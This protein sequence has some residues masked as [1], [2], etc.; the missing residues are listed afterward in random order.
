MSFHGGMLFLPCFTVVLNRATPPARR[1]GSPPSP[2]EDRL[3]PAIPLGEGDLLAT[4]WL[5]GQR[6]PPEPRAGLEAPHLLA[7]VGVKA[8]NLAGQLAGKPNPA[9]RRQHA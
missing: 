4:S 7:V 2:G 1:L 6:L 8:V 9:G 3:T 5:Q